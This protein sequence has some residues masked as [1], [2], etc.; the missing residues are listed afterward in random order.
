MLSISPSELRLYIYGALQEL[1]SYF[2]RI[3]R[4]YDNDEVWRERK[5][6]QGRRVAS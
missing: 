6:Y 4:G 1:L 5:G 3:T 2:L